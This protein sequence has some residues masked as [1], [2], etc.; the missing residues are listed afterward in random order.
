VRVSHGLQIV[1]GDDDG[2]TRA[3]VREALE[4]D[5]CEVVAEAGS[6]VAVVRA[7]VDLRP[8]VTLLDVRLPGGGISAARRIAG[9]LDGVAVVMLTDSQRDEHL[10]EALRAGASGYLLKDMDP[11]GL[12][13]RLHRILAGEIILPRSLRR[14]IA[15]EFSA[16]A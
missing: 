3:A 11:A 13:Q 12:A 14:G 9:E 8:D 4:R 7:T 10:I 2:P 5:G 16:G 6:A 1:I 15:E